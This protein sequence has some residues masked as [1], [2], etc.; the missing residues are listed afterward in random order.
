MRNSTAVLI[1]NTFDDVLSD[2]VVPELLSDLEEG[3]TEPLTDFLINLRNCA[4]PARLTHFHVRGQ[5]E[6]GEIPV[7][8]DVEGGDRQTKTALQNFLADLTTHCME[9]GHLHNNEAF[10]TYCDACKHKV[11]AS[12]LHYRNLRKKYAVTPMHH[13]ESALV[14]RLSGTIYST[15]FKAGWSLIRA[16]MHQPIHRE[17]RDELEHIWRQAKIDF[18]GDPAFGLGPIEAHEAQSAAVKFILSQLE[19]IQRLLSRPGLHQVSIMRLIAHKTRT[20]YDLGLKFEINPGVG[21]R[22][23]RLLRE[24]L[25]RDVTRML[26][27]V[28]VGDGDPNGHVL[29]RR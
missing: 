6:C 3:F 7:D 20:P 1:A 26:I 4:V 2:S 25:R 28:V 13:V 27:D 14:S 11:D 17:Y 8:I 9:C 15:A 16:G 22:I 21:D 18:P 24:L 29:F 12:T 23:P 19:A 5:R 10:G